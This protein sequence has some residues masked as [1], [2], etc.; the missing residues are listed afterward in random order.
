MDFSKKAKGYLNA[1]LNRQLMLEMLR[2]YKRPNDKI[3]ELIQNGELTALKK[4]LYIPGKVTELPAPEPFLIANHL[5]GPSYIS[6]ESALSYWGMIPERVFEI[7][8]VTIKTNKVYKT[9]AGRF[10]YRHIPLPYYAFGMQ[11][12]TL[13]KNQVAMV[14]SPEKAICDKI[15]TTSGIVLRSPA[16]ARDFL[17]EDLRTDEERLSKLNWKIIV[18]WAEDAPKKNS[19]LMLAKTLK[20]L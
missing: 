8:S 3:S 18:S 10:T 11:S 7:T 17:I 9:P 5:W 13:S 16:Q 19:L 6:L 12:I 4:G 1:P 2:G 14:A 15:V 20:T